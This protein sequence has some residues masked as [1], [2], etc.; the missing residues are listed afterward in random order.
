VADEVLRSYLGDAEPQAFWDSVASN[1]GSRTVR[2]IFVADVIPIELQRIIEFLNDQLRYAE[3][4]GIE[5][6]QYLAPGGDLQ[7]LVPRVVGRT[8]RASDVKAPRPR[9]GRAWD[10]ATF[11]EALAANGVDPT[12]ARQLLAWS[13]DRNLDVS[14]GTGATYGTLRIKLAIAERMV[15]LTGIDTTG[16]MLWEPRALEPFPPFDAEEH[17][18][19]VVRRLNAVPGIV[20]P[21]KIANGAWAHIRPGDLADP[22][23]H[24]PILDVVGWIADEV[25]SSTDED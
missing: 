15:P 4:L 24:Q 12:F 23:R 16:K 9:S 2:L 11:F 14:W 22:A 8:A 19:E 7:V 1:L 6:Q 13:R 21:D 17:R 25:R 20:L 3:V 10:E 5:V 18:V